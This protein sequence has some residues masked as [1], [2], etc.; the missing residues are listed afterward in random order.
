MQTKNVKLIVQVSLVVDIFLCS[1]Q[2]EKK[3]KSGLTSSKT[4]FSQLQDEVSAGIRTKQAEK[5]KLAANK[6]A[7]VK[8]FKL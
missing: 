5:R 8:K 4:F 2:D 1:P 6:P 7:G 3:A